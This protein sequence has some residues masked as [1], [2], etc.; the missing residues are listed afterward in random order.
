MR[1]RSIAVKKLFGMFD[2]AI[3]LNREEKI[4]I[5]YGPNGYGKTYILNTM[6]ALFNGVFE[7]IKEVPFL[8]FNVE[9]DDGGSVIVTRQ[10]D[11]LYGGCILS[12]ADAAGNKKLLS[13]DEFTKTIC[14]HVRV[15][16]IDTGRLM[17]FSDIVDDRPSISIS[18][19]KMKEL[20]SGGIDE[21]TRGKIDLFVRIIN[22]RFSHKTIVIDEETGF[23]FRASNGLILRPEQLSSGEQHAV[24]ILLELLFNTVPGTLILI[25][26]PELSLHISWQQQ[27]VRD[28]DEIVSHDN[29]DILIATHSPQIIHDRWDLTV[30][31]KGPGE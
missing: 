29:F 9:L 24:V 15:R 17:R 27:F 14:R 11:E 23:T 30:E 18:A 16:S 4:T 3:P 10:R 13:Q 6:H 26:E 7:D 8:E 5:V 21:E 1:I 12:V 22:S 20:I 31:L 25:D 28:I 2:H 19:G